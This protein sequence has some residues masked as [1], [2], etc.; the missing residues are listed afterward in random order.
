M[1]RAK[2]STRV[3]Q[4]KRKTRGAAMKPFPDKRKTINPAVGK[5]VSKGSKP[6]VWGGLSQ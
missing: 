4:T 3:K 2:K 1:A 5:K 6:R